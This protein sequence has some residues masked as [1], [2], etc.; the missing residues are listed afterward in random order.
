MTGVQTCALP[1]CGNI[2][3]TILAREIEAAKTILV[4]VYPSRGLDIGATETVHRLLVSQRDAGLGV[5]FFSEDLDE[6][7]HISDRIAVLFEG[8]IMGIFDANTVT[9][10][11]LGLLMAGVR[12]EEGA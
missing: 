6:L 10:E 9:I 8:R 2:Q 12:E 7:L 5:L 11:R 1:I 3:K 4:A